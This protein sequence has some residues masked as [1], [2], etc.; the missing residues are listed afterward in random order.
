MIHISYDS[1]VTVVVMLI[2]I[3][4]VVLVMAVTVQC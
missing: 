3:E 4:K 2:V 1:T